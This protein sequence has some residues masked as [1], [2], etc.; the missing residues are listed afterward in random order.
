MKKIKLIILTSIV[1]LVLSGCKNSNE[2]QGNIENQKEV[3]LPSVASMHKNRNETKIEKEN[4]IASSKTIVIDP[5]HSSVGNRDQ[6]PVSPGLSETKAKDVLGATGSY[7]NIPENETTISVSLLLKEKLE[8]VGYN[9]I[10]TKKSV[11]ESLSNI[12]RANIGNKNNADLVIR[13]HADSAN[14][15]SARGASALV[16]SINQYT[17]GIYNLSEKY[18]T[19]ILNTYTNELNIHSRGVIE[20]DDITGFNWSKVPVVILEMGFLSNENEDKFI[21]N[22]ENHEKIATAIANGVNNCFLK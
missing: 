8:K 12:E 2:T 11:S 16:P 7:T 19:S 20:R 13:I 22:S 9:V 5:G 4:E 10:M 15:S 18:G 1:V 3:S 14:S 21:S 6:E 17:Q